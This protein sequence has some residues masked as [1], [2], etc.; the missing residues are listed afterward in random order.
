MSAA[1]RAAYRPV[2]AQHV[3][4]VYDVRRIDP[5][6]H[7]PEEQRIDI[8]CEKCK[9]EHVVMCRTGHVRQH[10]VNFARVHLHRDPF[11]SN[12]PPPMA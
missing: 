10:V 2:F 6:T 11:M 5:E 4:G 8:V 12:T 3:L 1:P 9:A 7:E